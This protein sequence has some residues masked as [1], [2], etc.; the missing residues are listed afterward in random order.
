MWFKINYNV[1]NKWYTYTMYTIISV[2][3]NLYHISYMF[4]I[5][6]YRSY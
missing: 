6:C 5:K 2:G 4:L 1:T 3:L